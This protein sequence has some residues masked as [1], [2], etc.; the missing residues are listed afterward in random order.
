MSISSSSKYNSVFPLDHRAPQTH[1]HMSVQFKGAPSAHTSGVQASPPNAY[2][3]QSGG[4]Q[5]F[6]SVHTVPVQYQNPASN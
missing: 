4:P 3:I 6:T 1:G 5:G 2:G